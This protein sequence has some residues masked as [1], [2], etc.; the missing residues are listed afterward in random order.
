M[1][2]AR[3]K[4][5]VV[6]D[7]ESV[8]ELLKQI[9]TDEGYHVI[10]AS[11]GEEALLKLSEESPQVMTLDDKMPGMSGM[12]A[13]ARLS[14]DQPGVYI[15]MVTAVI[16]D[17]SIVE[18]MKMG[19]LDYI[20]K[21]FEREEVLRKVRRAIQSWWRLPQKRQSQA[22]RREGI[23]EHTERMHGQCDEPAM[24]SSG[25][26]GLLQRIAASQPGHGKA[27][28]SVLPLEL[29]NPISYVEEF[30]ESLIRILRRD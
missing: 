12:E 1:M 4:I 26:H 22:K 16:D 13:L 15:I 18:A 11:D 7:E 28:M 3:E 21:P 19:A 10:T 8:C 9:L 2:Q 24:A 29:Q 27:V 5:L 17:S 25:E 23:T 30:R 14:Q 20:T 6:D